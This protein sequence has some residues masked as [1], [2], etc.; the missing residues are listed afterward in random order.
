M[1]LLAS[2]M[3]FSACKRELVPTNEWEMNTVVPRRRIG[4]LYFDSEQS[5]QKNRW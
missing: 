1:V 2:G 4:L 5:L 3:S